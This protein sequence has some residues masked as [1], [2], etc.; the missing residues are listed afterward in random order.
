MY[1]NFS[2]ILDDSWICWVPIVTGERDHGND[3]D[4]DDGSF[5]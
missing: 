4:D 2:N 1:E 5:L 3:D